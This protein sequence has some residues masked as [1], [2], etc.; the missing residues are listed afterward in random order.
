MIQLE[1]FRL[2]DLTLLEVQDRHSAV[3][4]IVLSRPLTATVALE[5]PWSWTAW[6]PYGVPVACCGVLDNGIAWALLSPD[7]GPHMV[8]ITR[9]SRRVF[10]MRRELGLPTVATVDDSHDAAV[11]WVRMLGF[12]QDANGVWVFGA[13]AKPLRSRLHHDDRAGDR[14]D[15][16]GAGGQG[17]A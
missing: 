14:H 8:A 12:R 7:A 6:L 9:A 11:R 13:D 4:Q 17:A 3:P 2:A 15:R 16:A 5:G 1:P 10:E